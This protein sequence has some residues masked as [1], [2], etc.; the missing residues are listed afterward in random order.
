MPLWHEMIIQ[1]H[2]SEDGW[3]SMA[4]QFTQTQKMCFI[5]LQSCNFD[6]GVNQHLS[7]TFLHEWTYEQTDENIISS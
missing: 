2:I 4:F 1:V 7:T 6:N 3:N 5:L